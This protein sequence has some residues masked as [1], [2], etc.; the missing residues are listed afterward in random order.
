MNINRLFFTAVA[1]FATVFLTRM[2]ASGSSPIQSS[3]Q[4]KPTQAFFRLCSDCHDADRIVSNRR[5][6]AGWEE[7]LAK[8]VDKGATGSDQDFELVLYYLL[9]HYGQVNVNKSPAEEIQVVLGLTQKDVDAIAA[10]RK[11]NGD[12]K[13]FDALLKVPG[14]DADKIDKLKDNREAILF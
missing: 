7:V 2:S 6:R 14:I 11:A 12:I 3:S 10:Y 13:D 8:M 5:T 1:V 9:S 4:D